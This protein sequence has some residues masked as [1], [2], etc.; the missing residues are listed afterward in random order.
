[1]L[2][3]L[4]EEQQREDGIEE[5]KIWEEN[6][7][8]VRKAGIGKIWAKE[9]E[10]KSKNYEKQMEKWNDQVIVNEKERREK[11]ELQR[12]DDGKK[13]L[14]RGETQKENEQKNSKEL[15]KKLK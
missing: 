10:D 11:R 2:R 14:T 8:K 15:K 13:I 5:G 7:K 12:L 9:D 6:V 1:M 3:V 4:E